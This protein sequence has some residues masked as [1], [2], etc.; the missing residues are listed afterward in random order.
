MISAKL[1]HRLD[2]PLTPLSQQITLTGITPNLLTVLGFSV[3]IAAACSFAFGMPRLGGFLILLSGGF[4]LLDGA[5]AR[6]T[7]KVTKFGAFLDSVLD[8][9]SDAF[10]FLGIGIYL[11]T[12]PLNVLL[13]GL[14]LIGTFFVS[15]ARARAEG[16]GL[17]CTTGLMERTERMILMSIGG[18]FDI[19]VP[20]L[21]I[22]LVLTH[23]TALQRIHYIWSMTRTKTEG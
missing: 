23:F 13:V 20:V 10:L 19:F 4:D 16:L 12:D 2:K 5:V 15:Y 18:I 7:G 3:S 6:T 9:Y 1:G 21:W 8:R 17:T 14:T 22:L 11:F